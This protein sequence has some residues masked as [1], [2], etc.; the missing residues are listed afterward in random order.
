MKRRRV[1]L[2]DFSIYLSCE[3][4]LVKNE[5]RRYVTLRWDATFFYRKC[6][7]LEHRERTCDILIPN[8]ITKMHK[9]K[10]ITLGRKEE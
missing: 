10:E 3:L 9:E 1:H 8:I 7:Y 5:M 4:Q 2:L 6:E